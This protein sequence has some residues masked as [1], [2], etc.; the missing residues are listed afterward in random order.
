MV[1]NLGTRYEK[2]RKDTAD[3]KKDFERISGERTELKEEFTPLSQLIDLESLVDDEAQKAITDVANV[4]TVETQRLDS[5]TENAE[6]NKDEI[7]DS[8]G[9]ELSK[10]QSGLEKINSANSEFGKSSIEQAKNE[11]NTQIEKFNEL[12]DELGEK[13][14]NIESHSIGSSEGNAD[15]FIDISD[16]PVLLNDGDVIDIPHNDP[17]NLMPNNLY[18]SASS[19][20]QYAV[21][22]LN[23]SNV[24][25][26]PIK[27]YQEE[28]ASED[29]INDLSGGDLTAGS[30]SSLALAYAGNRG[31]YR[32][33]DFRDGASR[34]YFSSRSSIQ[35]I[36]ELPDVRSS[37]LN[38]TDDIAST[39]QLL[40]FM[41]P[42]NE[43]YLATGAHASIVRRTEQG[44]EYLE[45]QHPSNGNGWH[46]L[47]NDI[48][49]ARFGCK[50]NRPVPN[51]N[52]L[53]DV[54]SLSGNQEFLSIL[55]YINTA[56]SE[57][58][59][60]GTGNVR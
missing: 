23:N 58:R 28:V 12:L 20:Y 37:I 7:A 51:S 30:C 2:N 6:H 32:V 55:G 60:G 17:N 35:R 10:L 16:E 41:V 25:Y 11:Y 18:S 42:G 43:Y 4:E 9:G 22:T 57:Q 59:K 48:L 40:N 13:P 24:S 44:Y 53:I 15:A 31:G 50:T 33:L 45:L 39:N 34:D 14:S 38:G 36:T 29:I 21:N 52:F 27:P 19:S 49:S 26:N 1:S 46:T 47:N 54:N 3:N 8:I 5:E 56:E